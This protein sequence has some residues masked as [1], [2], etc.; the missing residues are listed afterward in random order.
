LH[1][2]GCSYV[3]PC[4]NC[5]GGLALPVVAPPAGVASTLRCLLRRRHRL[6]SAPA[7]PAGAPAGRPTSAA[8]APPPRPPAGRAAPRGHRAAAPSSSPPPPARPAAARCRR[9]P[10]SRPSAAAAPRARPRRRPRAAAAARSGRTRRSAT[11]GTTTTTTRRARGSWCVR[12]RR[13]RRGASASAR[14]AAPRGRRPCTRVAAWTLRYAGWLTRLCCGDATPP[15]FRRLAC[16]TSPSLPARP[17]TWTPSSRCGAPGAAGSAGVGQR[18]GAPAWQSGGAGRDGRH[19][20]QRG[21]RV[22]HSQ[23]CIRMP[24]S[25]KSAQTIARRCTAST[26][27]PTTR[28]RG[29]ASAST[30]AAAP[31]SWRR[32]PRGSGGSSPTPTA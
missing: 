15:G 8:A 30:P 5:T 31:A 9:A 32:R 26:R 17:P 1:G 13:R 21:T 14:R 24:N 27:S 19:A 22:D 6:R 3:R 29:S 20:P 25:L 12:R 10:R 4:A 23:D 16:A 7:H 28:C 11:T 2:G 18:R